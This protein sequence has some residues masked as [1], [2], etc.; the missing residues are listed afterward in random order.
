MFPFF[1]TSL[2]CFKNDEVLIAAFEAKYPIKET[3]SI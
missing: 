2:N 1:R 3:S